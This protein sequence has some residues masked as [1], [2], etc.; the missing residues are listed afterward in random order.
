MEKPILS[1]HV[2]TAIKKRPRFRARVLRLVILEQAGRPCGASLDDVKEEFWVLYGYECSKQLVSQQVA[3][4][5]RD[6]LLAR[7]G[8]GVY[9]AVPVPEP[10][11]QEA[12]ARYPIPT[13]GIFA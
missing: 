5:V 1:S 7:R 10:K 13:D 3:L 6:K 11:A 4:L 8:W 9:Q 12:A 2:V